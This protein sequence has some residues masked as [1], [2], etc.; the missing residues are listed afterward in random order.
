VLASEPE[1]HRTAG[2]T[3]L[4]GISHAFADMADLKTT[5]TRS[6]SS[7]VARLSEGA[8]AHMGLDTAE[9]TNVKRAALFHDLGRVGIPNGVWEKPRPLS[10]SDWE[11]VRLHPY[12][13]ERILSRSTALEHLAPAAGMHHERQDATGYHRQLSK[14]AISMPA[15]I[16][17]AADT[18][19]AMTSM[20]PYRAAVDPSAAAGV[21]EQ[22]V[23]E[24]KLDGQA[25]TAVLAAAG[26]AR[27][28]RSAW[29]DSLTDREIEVLRL[30]S[31]GASQKDVGKALV[32]SHRTAA[33]HIQHIYDKIGISTRAAAA[34][35]AMEHDLLILNPAL[36]V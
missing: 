10:A 6:H 8:A 33:H 20:R 21:M 25:V 29:P 34:M 18:Y 31:R 23:S 13:S 15:R 4:D 12:Y 17:A 2:E 24:G 28:A 11:R 27:K 14:A 36:V 30:I 32:I 19:Q 9:I 16:L 35:Y 7:E 3:R 22:E 5:F 1:P 26:H